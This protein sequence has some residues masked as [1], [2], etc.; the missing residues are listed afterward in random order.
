MILAFISI[1]Y[2]FPKINKKCLKLSDKKNIIRIF[3]ICFFTIIIEY[4]RPIIRPKTT[5]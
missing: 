3:V 2:L 1:L 5:I 4:E